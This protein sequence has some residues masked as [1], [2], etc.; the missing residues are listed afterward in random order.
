MTQDPLLNRLR[1]NDVLASCAIANPEVVIFNAPVGSSSS[2]KRSLLLP[3]FVQDI[4][5][6][7]RWNF[8]NNHRTVGLE[9]AADR[10]LNE[11]HAAPIGAI[12]G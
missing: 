7:I 8:G 6:F 9:P 3:D 10:L 2:V 11:G 12:M 4:C 1:A 5:K